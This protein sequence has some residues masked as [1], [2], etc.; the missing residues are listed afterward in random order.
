M[1][2]RP[3]GMRGFRTSPREARV[4][5]AAELEL[6]REVAKST[7]DRVWGLGFIGFIGFGV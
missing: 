1:P 6:E 2:C 5:G 4:H 7:G 3:Q